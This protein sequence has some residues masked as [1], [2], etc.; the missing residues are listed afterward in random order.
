MLKYIKKAFLFHW[1][2]LA[3]TTGIAG[4]I[5]SGRPD[6]VM[7]ALAALEV[8]YLAA[9]ASH[10]RFQDAVDAAEQKDVHGTRHT[11]DRKLYQML[12][13][14]NKADRRRYEQLKNLC[15]ELRH[16]A[17]RVKR[18]TEGLAISDVQLNSI[19][20]LLWIYLKLLYSKNALE[21]FFAAINVEDI[22]ARIEGS[23]QR[24]KA[25]GQESDDSES[26]SLSRK[27]LMDTLATSRQ[28]LKN[29]RISMENYDFIGLELERLHAKI[30]SLA[31]MGISRQDPN[32][33]NSEINVVSS[34]I[35]K[36]EKAMNELDFITG[37][38]FQDEEPPALLEERERRGKIKLH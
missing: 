7:P 28:R 31:E 38:A 14:L 8:I 13:S 17:T 18:S 10:P 2:L 1:N 27:S 5:I 35:E 15:L 36:T 19:N 11:S 32:F 3:V 6:V 30:A 12:A 4:G 24:L 16:I 9:L 22:Q 37:G 21:S 29:Y 20:R 25:M 26:E 34:S 23:E 33:I